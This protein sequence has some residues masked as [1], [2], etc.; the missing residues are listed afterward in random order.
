MFKIFQL[1]LLRNWRSIAVLFAVLLLSNVGFLMMRQLTAN[2]EQQVVAQTAPLFGADIRIS[3]QD[4]QE[5]PLFERVAPYLSGVS[6]SWAERIEFSTTLF[7]Q[8][9]KT[10]LVNVIAYTGVYPQK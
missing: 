9:Q 3:S 4:D 8:D 10:G 7:D 6:Y 1:T 2:I 5:S